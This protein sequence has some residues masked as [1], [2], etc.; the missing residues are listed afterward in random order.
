MARQEGRNKLIQPL[1]QRYFQCSRGYC[2]A[3]F[4]IRNDI[5]VIKGG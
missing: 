1:I 2:G 3:S 4:Y 5:C